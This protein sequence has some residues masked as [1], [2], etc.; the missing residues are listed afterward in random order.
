M[1]NR[2]NWFRLDN[3][4]KIFP[5]TSTKKDPKVF[6][7]SCELYEDVDPS[8]LQKAL[9]KSLEVFPDY[10]TILKAGLFWYYL[11]TTNIHPKVVEEYLPPCSFHFKRA[12]S[13]LFQVTYYRKRI[14]LEMYHVLTDGTGA[15]HFL[16]TI[17][18]YYL[19]LA[20]PK[21]LGHIKLLYDA[22]DSEKMDDSFE[23][24]YQFKMAPS[25]SKYH[26]YYHIRGEKLKDFRM[27][28]I[29]GKMSL[30]KLLD[31]A[32]EYDATL[33]VFLLALY[34]KSIG[35]TMRIRDQKKAIFINLPINL[36]NY[37]KSVTARNF[38]SVIP[39]G[40][41][42]H[43][44]SLEEIVAYVKDQFE[45]IL[46]EE[47]L[48]K[49][50]NSFGAVE[51]NYIIR[52]VPL[53][54]KD[55]VLFY[56]DQVLNRKITA[57]LSNVGKIELPE[58][59]TPYIHSFSGLM[60]TESQQIVVCSFQDVITITFGST[61]KNTEVIKNFFR[62]ITSHGIDVEITSNEVK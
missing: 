31:L 16:K 58:E 50:M 18:S 6:R 35:E 22:S 52:L 49:R 60:S 43:G 54:I 7:F 59:Y 24:Y 19:T 29:E 4:A 8:V 13:L 34:Y 62:Y 38:F 40:Y 17:V 37:F 36:R 32:H 12:N 48:D 26:D 5:P 10:Q 55:I 25:L 39:V 2:K 45:K 9:D 61:Y 20:H 28:V 44:E 57:A 41:V 30:S 21:K 51:H 47:E 46:N 1:S 56:V 14:N 53:F 15:L 27:R 42:Y 23:K 3:A 33:S 11:E